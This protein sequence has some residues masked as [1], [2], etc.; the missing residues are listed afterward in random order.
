ME[1]DSIDER[2]RNRLTPEW[3]AHPVPGRPGLTLVARAGPEKGVDLDRIPAA[4]VTGAEIE[5]F[6]PIFRSGPARAEQWIA[7]YDLGELTQLA[8]T[9][10]QKGRYYCPQIKPPTGE[11]PAPVALGSPPALLRAMK[12]HHET[13]RQ[14][15]RGHRRSQ[16]KLEEALLRELRVLWLETLMHRAAAEEAR[17]KPGNSPG[18]KPESR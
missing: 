8:R 7:D 9:G 3:I 12:K 11:M 4:I 16:Q 18:R 10:G 6:A 14:A 15:A 17:T 1:R 5:A 2:I 13:A